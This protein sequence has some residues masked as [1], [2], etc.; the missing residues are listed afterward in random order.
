[1]VG[2]WECCNGGT[3][4]ILTIFRAKITVITARTAVIWRCFSLR[5]LAH[6]HRARIRLTPPLPWPQIPNIAPA[7]SVSSSCAMYDR[8]HF[9]RGDSSHLLKNWPRLFCSRKSA[10]NT[11]LQKKSTIYAT[12]YLD[13]QAVQVRCSYCN[14]S[15]SCCQAMLGCQALGT[16]K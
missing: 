11:V 6:Q 14:I 12:R 5:S 4:R 1:M 2:R 15:A 9:F 8:P 7:I 10:S 3:A 16:F 13:M